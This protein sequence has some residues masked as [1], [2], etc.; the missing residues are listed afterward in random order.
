MTQYQQ[1]ASLPPE[2][3]ERPDSSFILGQQGQGN[4]YIFQQGEKTAVEHY[5]ESL[6]GN[7][8]EN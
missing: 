1:Q 4:E 8:L 6:A 2:R 5:E 7:T 3:L